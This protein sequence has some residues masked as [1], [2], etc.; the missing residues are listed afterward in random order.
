MILHSSERKKGPF[1]DIKYYI[2]DIMAMVKEMMAI[3]VSLKDVSEWPTH[4]L[5]EIY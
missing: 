5:F 4:D 2:Y 1:P 3:E